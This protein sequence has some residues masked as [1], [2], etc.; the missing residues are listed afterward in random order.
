V[1]EIIERDGSVVFSVRVTP[2]AGRDAI[3]GEYQDALRFALPP[4]RL[5]IALTMLF[6]FSWP[7]V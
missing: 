4:H 2:R 6:D 5:K 7:R 3:E 1:I